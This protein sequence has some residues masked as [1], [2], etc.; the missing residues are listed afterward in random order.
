LR[1]LIKAGIK[2]WVETETC[3]T[4]IIGR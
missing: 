3:H 4:D 1:K 2:C